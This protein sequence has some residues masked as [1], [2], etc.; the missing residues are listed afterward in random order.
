[1]QIGNL[2]FRFDYV[3]PCIE[4]ALK[5]VANHISSRSAYFSEANDSLRLLEIS[6]FK[7]LLELS[8]SQAQNL[9]IRQNLIKYSHYQIFIRTLN[10]RTKTIE[11]GSLDS[12]ENIKVKIHEIEGIPPDLQRLMFG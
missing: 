8:D 2:L 4:D 3:P 11:I 7:K 12:I 5:I 1:M 10:G 9:W 6:K